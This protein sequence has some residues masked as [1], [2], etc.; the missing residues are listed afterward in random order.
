MSYHWN[1]T[2]KEIEDWLDIKIHKFAA[3]ENMNL[4]LTKEQWLD[5]YMYI[6][7]HAI[8]LCS[9]RVE[10]YEWIAKFADSQGRWRLDGPIVWTLELV[11]RLEASEDKIVLAV[12]HWIDC[13]IGGFVTEFVVDALISYNEVE[14]CFVNG[15]QG[16]YLRSLNTWIKMLLFEKWVMQLP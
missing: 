9:F 15:P 12:N 8:F 13:I 2:K 4:P 10:L 16:K 3:Q 6:E 14:R 1:P 5:I 7:I 11:R